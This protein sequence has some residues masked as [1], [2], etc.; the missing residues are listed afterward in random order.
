M[1]FLRATHLCC[2][3]HQSNVERWH[4]EAAYFDDVATANASELHLDSAILQRYQGPL[5]SIY[6]KEFL[7]RFLGDLTGRHVLDLGCGEGCNSVLLA[8]RGAKVTGIDVSPKS[9]ELAA[10]RAKAN[11]VEAQCEFV[12]SAIE[13]AKIPDKSF[14]GVWI[15][16]LF[17]HLIPELD[18]VLPRIRAWCK[19]NARVAIN[20]PVSLSPFLRWVR[21][22]VPVPL[23]ATPDER[24]LRPEELRKIL[25]YFPELKVQYSHLLARLNR[26]ILPGVNNYES[27]SSIRR[28]VVDAIQ[29]IDYVLLALPGVRHFAGSV[30]M[31][32]E[33]SKTDSDKN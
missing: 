16:D 3:G 27:A 9:V 19:G 26:V 23:D 22:F 13:L 31:Y 33:I 2:R 8:K 4:S 17:H 12:C 14:D 25:S 20:E 5:R 7:L 21:R 28:R 15:N 29:W 6:A 10:A 18:C 11:G 32:G 1:N 24:P 30:S